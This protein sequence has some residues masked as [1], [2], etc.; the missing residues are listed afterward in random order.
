MKSKMK[1]K[2]SVVVQYPPPAAISP[3]G[4]IHAVAVV[5]GDGRISCYPAC[6]MKFDLTTDGWFVNWKGT[7]K[8]PTCAH[9][10]RKLNDGY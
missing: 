10:M 2:G 4:K 6:N 1:R 9:C 5:M 7:D 3:T 8:H